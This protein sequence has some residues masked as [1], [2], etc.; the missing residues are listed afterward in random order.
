LHLAFLALKI[1]HASGTPARFFFRKSLPARFSTDAIQLIASDI[2]T[3]ANVRVII[4]AGNSG[5]LSGLAEG[6]L[7]EKRVSLRRIKSAAVAILSSARVDPMTPLLSRSL[8]FRDRNPLW[9]L[10]GRLGLLFDSFTSRSRGLAICLGTGVPRAEK[11]H[12]G[13]EAV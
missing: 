2:S 9:A 10:P 11:D 6:W 5:G 8:A 13:R 12:E 1:P 7:C 3:C 4:H